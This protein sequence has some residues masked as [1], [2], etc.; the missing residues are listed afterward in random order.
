MLGN[1]ANTIGGARRTNNRQPPASHISHRV[2]WRPRFPPQQP[3]LE[4]SL[5][6]RVDWFRSHRK[7]V[8][9]LTPEVQTEMEEFRTA[10]SD[11]EQ[12]AFTRQDTSTQTMASDI[13]DLKAILQEF[14]QMRALA[15]SLDHELAVVEMMAE[16]N[17]QVCIA[18]AVD[19][20]HAQ[21]RE[22]MGSLDAASQARLTHAH[23]A[24]HADTH[25]KIA[26]ITAEHT[27]AMVARIKELEEQHQAV[28]SAA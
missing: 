26:V 24:A 27:K 6:T 8:L 23:N 28:S 10:V 2:L 9:S 12:I 3:S 25:A 21:V 17:T 19:G 15:E 13:A 4:I 5:I 16:A 18:E 14:T 1:S 7:I 20:L 11:I 22:R